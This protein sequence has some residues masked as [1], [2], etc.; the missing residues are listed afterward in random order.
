[1]FIYRHAE[2]IDDHFIEILFRRRLS[3]IFPVIRYRTTIH[4]YVNIHLA[5]QRKKKKER[6]K[7]KEETENDKSHYNVLLLY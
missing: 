4:A 6:K 7:N 3:S 2:I 5:A 1:M